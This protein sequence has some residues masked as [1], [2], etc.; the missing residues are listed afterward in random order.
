[1][2]FIVKKV[3]VTLSQ[4]AKILVCVP[5]FN[6]GK[7]I[8]EIVTKSKK[9]ADQVLVYDDGST[10]DT[11]ELATA[12]GAMVIKSPN[13]TGYGSAIRALFQAARE[14]NA[15]IMVT[16]DSDGQHDPD[17]IP[18]LIEPIKRGFDIVIGSRFLRDED[19]E[20]VPKYRSI[21]IKTITRLAQAASY[22]GITDSQS[23]FRAYT[24]NALDQ[25]NLFEDGMSVSTEILLRASEKKLSITEVPISVYYDMKD[26][27]THNPI[28]HGVGI[29]YSMLQYISLRHPLAFYGIPGIILLGVAAFFIRNALNLFSNSGYVSTNMILVAVGI[30]VVGMILL[31]TAAIVYTL[32]A[33]LRDKIR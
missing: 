21:G 16:L 24:K 27:S 20:K 1:M 22:K 23:G 13:N 6:E 15:D 2:E 26:T 28:S 9:Y 10:D 11:S 8:S 17:Q 7:N 12:A 25:I 29:V 32:I 19:K 5:A 4:D 3:H 18:D 31:A 33:L 14:Q 30:A